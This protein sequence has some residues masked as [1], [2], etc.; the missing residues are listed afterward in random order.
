V[1]VSYDPV[2]TLHAIDT[3]LV[4][5]LLLVGLCGAATFAYL[6]SS[7]RVA[8]RHRA[9]PASPLA[10]GFFGVHDLTF[11]LAWPQWF[12][13]GPLS[14][15]WTMTWCVALGFTSLIE[16]A[17]VYQGFRFGR[18][19]L[20]P[21]ATQAQFGVALLGAMV[22]IAALWVVVKSVLVDDLFLISFAI[23]AWMGPVFST[24]LLARRGS[25]RGQTMFMA[26]CL[27]VVQVGMFSAWTLLDPWFR[28]VGFLT[29]GVLAVVGAGFNVWLM[30]RYPAYDPAADRSDPAA[31]P[32]RATVTS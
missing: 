17:L 15:W 7:F 23:T 16:F 20:M 4:P 25:R 6:V 1:P 19:E 13:G 29:L 8:N 3:H 32:S 27:L 10:V 9:F 31:V 18:A 14:G 12:G 30:S 11:V 28:G 22:L 2:S 24:I 5:V 26:W 21:R